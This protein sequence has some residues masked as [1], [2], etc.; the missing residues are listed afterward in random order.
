MSI[1]LGTTDALSCL[2]RLLLLA[3]LDT[4]SPII[5]QYFIDDLWS[6]AF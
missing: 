3:L 4:I 5:I 1:D 2:P 6:I